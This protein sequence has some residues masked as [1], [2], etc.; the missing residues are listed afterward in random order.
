M[1][2]IVLLGA[3]LGDVEQTFRHARE[4][5]EERVGRICSM[6]GVMWSEAW[7]FEVEN[8]FGNQ[9]LKVDTPLPPESLLDALQ[10]IEAECGRN[11]DEEVRYKQQSGSRYCSRMLDADI[12]FYGDERIATERL[13]VPHPLLPEREFAL[14]PIAEI[15][16]QRRHPVNGATIE[17]MLNQVTARIR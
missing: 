5:I 1:D 15:E 12:I 6:S 9:A 3:N 11:R 7:G 2:A 16:P 14:R 17:E 10:A 13:A 8:R 4:L